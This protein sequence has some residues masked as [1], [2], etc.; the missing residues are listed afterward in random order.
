MAICL[1]MVPGILSGQIAG[2]TVGERFLIALVAC[3][4]FG[5]ILSWVLNTY[6]EQARRAEVMRIIHDSRRDERETGSQVDE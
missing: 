3:W 6:S 4:F 1:P 5:S 2:A